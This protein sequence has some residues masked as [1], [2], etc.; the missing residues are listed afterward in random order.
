MTP[1]EVKNFTWV[2]VIN[3]LST[4]DQIRLIDIRMEWRLKIGSPMSEIDSALDERNRIA[5]KHK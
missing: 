4:E 3:N 2:E 1:D 5:N